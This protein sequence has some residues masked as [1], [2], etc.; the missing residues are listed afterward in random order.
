[1]ERGINVVDK[2]LGL[3]PSP[4]RSAAARTPFSS[5][6]AGVILGAVAVYF[7]RSGSH[8]RAIAIALVPFAVLLLTRPSRGFAAGV[9]LMLT[10]PS[11]WDF[12]GRHLAQIAAILAA[13]A[14]LTGR[15]RRLGATDLSLITFVVV[16]VLGWLLQYDHPETW[17]VVLGMLTPV[18]F[19]LGARAI[20]RARMPQIMA[21]IL[22]AGTAG[23]LTVIYEFVRGAPV[24]V[25]PTKYLWNAAPGGLFRPGGVF[26][27]A[28][29]AATVLVIVCFFGMASLRTLHGKAR[30]LGR[31]CLGI[32]ALAAVLTFTR[33]PIIGG[34]AGLILFLWLVRSPSLR[35]KRIAIFGVS[36]V[37]IVLV[38]LPRLEHTSVFQQGVARKGNL[39][40]RESYWSLALPIAVASPHNFIFGIGT[41][42]LETPAI[43]PEAPLP[44]SVASAPQV[45]ENSLHN[46]YLTTFVEQGIIGVIWLVSL[47]AFGFF[48]AVRVAYARGDPTYAAVAAAILSLAVVF[49]VDTAVLD[50]PSLTMFMVTLGFA[51]TAPKKAA[52]RAEIHRPRD[53]S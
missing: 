12:G 9:V 24:F 14:A 49:A 51:A 37:L 19:Y 27:G 47:L 15:R 48:A 39:A 11:W 35:P 1:V 46:Q 28:P 31:V 45:V 25:D 21:V 5:L 20:P 17:H 32:C 42:L 41:G 52:G 23:A 36:F 16:V 30:T 8:S 38:A 34:G 13:A 18:G 10:V 2:P 3:R 53:C 7:M 6:A 4:L 50:A 44:L 22:F 40:A 29:A 26:G 43:A 33:T